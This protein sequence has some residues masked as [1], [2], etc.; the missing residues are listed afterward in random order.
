[1]CYKWDNFSEKKGDRGK[2]LREEGGEQGDPRKSLKYLFFWYAA[3]A[4]LLF[5]YS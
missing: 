5:V 4:V 3:A 1:M 2:S